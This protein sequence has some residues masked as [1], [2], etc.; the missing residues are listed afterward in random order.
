MRVSK[1]RAKFQDIGDFIGKILFFIHGDKIPDYNVPQ[2][3]L[4]FK[5]K[6]LFFI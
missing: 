1:E 3:S 6:I 4:N 2:H 5:L